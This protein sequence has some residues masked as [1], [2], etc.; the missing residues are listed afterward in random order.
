MSAVD[1]TKLRNEMVETQV[2]AR[3]IRS[4]RVL[5]AMRKV[6]REG[7]VPSRLSRYAYADEPLPIDE[8]QTISQPYIVASMID[9]LGL[10][11]GERVLEV[12]TG[13]GYAAAVLAEIAGEVFTIERHEKLART[14]RERLAS[15]GYAH[16]HVRHGDGTLGWP[17]AAPF[18]AIVVTAGGPSVPET[19]KRQLA[20]GG[21]LVIPVG[22]ESE[23]Q[24]LVRVT[25]VDA[26]R[27]DVEDLY[28][29]RFVPLVGAEGWK[30]D[31]PA[32]GEPP[33]EQRRSP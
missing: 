3:G 14:A 27:F 9:V 7:Y 12:G 29:V 28:A 5:A 15:D 25:R 8:D 19:L 20:I 17:D 30:E 22:E 18:D 6:R 4:P 11:G 2:A 23:R 32:G 21:R 24:R 13:S 31:A 33:S 16:V 10:H 26:T 1:Y